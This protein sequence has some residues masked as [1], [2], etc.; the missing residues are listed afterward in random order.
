[1]SARIDNWLPISTAPERVLVDTCISDENG[2]RNECTL[3]RVGSLWFVDERRSMYVY[4]VP[5]HWR[6]AAPPLLMRREISDAL[7]RRAD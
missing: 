5:T 7:D 4:Y 1:M 2:H 6:P 3:F